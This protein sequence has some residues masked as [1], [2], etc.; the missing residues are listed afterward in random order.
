M[1]KVNGKEVLYSTS[2][3][4]GP[5]EEAVLAPAEL[6]GTKITIHAVEQ[7]DG[8]APAALKIE[9]VTGNAK[10]SLPFLNGG[11]FSAVLEMGMSGKDK[12]SAR[13]VGQGFN[14]TMVVHFAM[15]LEREPNYGLRKP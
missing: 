9:G 8:A 6:R 3:I 14:G 10:I 15:Y 12:V 1:L 11:A 7:P 5:G 13:V 4:I 2:F